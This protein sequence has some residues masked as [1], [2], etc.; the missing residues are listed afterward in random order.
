[1]V[2]ETHFITSCDHNRRHPTNFPSLLLNLKFIELGS[3]GLIVLNAETLKNA[4][5]EGYNKGYSVRGKKNRKPTYDELPHRF[6]VLEKLSWQIRTSLTADNL[7][8]TAEIL[9][10]QLHFQKTLFI[11]IVLIAYILR[12]NFDGEEA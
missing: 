9:R 11:V 5:K 7:A 6:E 8:A 10:D 12:M 2:F 4:K 1:M 3:F